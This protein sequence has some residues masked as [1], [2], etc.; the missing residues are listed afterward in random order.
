MAPNGRSRKHREPEPTQAT[1][2]EP[3]V[4]LDG[5]DDD[6]PATAYEARATL[7]LLHCP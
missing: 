6:E 1:Q 3:E 5:G 4:D 7:G 2:E